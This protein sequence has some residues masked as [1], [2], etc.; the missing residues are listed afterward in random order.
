VRCITKPSVRFR[1]RCVAADP[2]AVPSVE[3]PPPDYKNLPVYAL[4]GLKQ[5]AGDDTCSRIRGRLRLGPETIP[6]DEAIVPKDVINM[7]D[8][9]DSEEI[10]IMHSLINLAS[11]VRAQELLT[12]CC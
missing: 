10:Y 4:R 11:V 2:D 8:R 6:R 1:R 12:P 9:T 7:M 5:A 3:P